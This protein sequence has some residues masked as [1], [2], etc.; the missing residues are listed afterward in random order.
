MEFIIEKASTE[1]LEEIQSL[2]KNTIKVTAGKDYNKAQIMAWVSSIEN[3][4]RWK[5]KI[6]NQYFIVAKNNNKIV[7]FGSL[8]K[9]Y[10]D[11]LF[12]HKN[13]V[14]N[15]IASLIYKNLKEKSIQ[16]GFTKLTTYASIT[17]VPFF[18]SKDFK[19]IK[20]NKIIRK[21][22]EISNFEMSQ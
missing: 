18:Q 13:F 7:G 10:V 21:G 3:K 5:L 16:T 6:I 2:F 11:F 12:V 8:E 22:I 1:N 9:N 15:G 4:E 20:D 17:A 19:I 14:R